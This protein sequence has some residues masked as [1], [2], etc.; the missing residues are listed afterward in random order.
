MIKIQNFVGGEYQDPQSG[1]FLPVYNPATGEHYAD[2]PD[3]DGVDVVL[4]IQA[5]QKA[6]KTWSKIPAAHKI[7]LKTPMGKASLRRQ[8]MAPFW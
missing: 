7:F 6:F 2:C 4:G 5:A 3:S 8:R 1:K